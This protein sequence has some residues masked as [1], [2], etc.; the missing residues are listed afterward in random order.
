MTACAAVKDPPDGEM[1]GVGAVGVTVEET[2][3]FPHP[4][5]ARR[6]KVNAR[7]NAQAS[8]ACENK[9]LSCIVDGCTL[10]RVALSM[11]RHCRSD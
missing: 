4:L 6:L 5:V 3:E 8:L 10:A 9:R 2:D 1:D 7:P 11:Y